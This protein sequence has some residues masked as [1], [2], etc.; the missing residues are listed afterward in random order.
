MADLVYLRQGTYLP[1]IEEQQAIIRAVGIKGVDPERDQAWADLQPKRPRKGDDL[2]L[3]QRA[4]LLKAI[5]KGDRVVVA[6]PAILAASLTDAMPVLEVIAARGGTLF[7]AIDSTA[8][9]PGDDVAWLRF[10]QRI[11][12]DALDRRTAAMRAGR[13]AKVRRT[14][15]QQAAARALARELWT[16]PEVS[17]AQIEART[18]IS[19][20]TLYRWQRD[21][22]TW[23]QRESLPRTAILAKANAARK[24]KKR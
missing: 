4:W 5:R 22:P 14:A 20:P 12:R 3:P 13:A 21:D 18:G 15:E 2:G 23:P 7:V 6:A 8:I 24:G 11:E 16:R 9:A 10:G 17:V 1:S 19:S